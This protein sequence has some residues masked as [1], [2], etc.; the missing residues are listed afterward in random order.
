MDL[1]SATNSY[2]FPL[3]A[4]FIGNASERIYNQLRVDR[5]KVPHNYHDTTNESQEMQL[6]ESKE[7]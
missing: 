6:A 1:F 5:Y 4:T 3:E 2:I 7:K